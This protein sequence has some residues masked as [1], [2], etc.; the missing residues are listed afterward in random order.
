MHDPE[1]MHFYRWGLIPHWAKDAKIGYKMINARSETILEKAS[2]K[3]PMKNQRCLVWG[4]GFYEWKKEP[5][6]KAA[7]LYWIERSMDY[8]P[9]QV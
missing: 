6:S 2:F 8:L 1:H 9:W 3:G 4:D 7:L 5:G